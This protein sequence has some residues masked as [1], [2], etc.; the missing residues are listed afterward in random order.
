[1][2]ARLTLRKI[3]IPERVEGRRLKRTIVWNGNCPKSILRRFSPGILR[4]G[5]EIKLF[6]KGG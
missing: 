5:Y 6:E 3:E 2:R 4:S 1:L